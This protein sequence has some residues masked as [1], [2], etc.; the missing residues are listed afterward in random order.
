MTNHKYIDTAY[1]FLIR[2]I[3]SNGKQQNTMVQ[4]RRYTDEKPIGS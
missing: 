2:E 3:V 4:S 1:S